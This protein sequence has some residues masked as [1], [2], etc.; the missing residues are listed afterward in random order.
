MTIR[1]AMLWTIYAGCLAGFCHYALRDDPGTLLVL[2]C[3]AIGSWVF[4]HRVE[5]RGRDF[6]PARCD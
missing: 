3:T 6:D 4:I 1:T 5:K 2:W